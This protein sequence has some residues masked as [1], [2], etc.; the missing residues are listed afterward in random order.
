[1]SIIEIAI[2]AVI[3]AAVF[4]ALRRIVRMRRSG[5][6]CGCS[7]CCAACGGECGMTRGK[8]DGSKQAR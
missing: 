2:V 1:M 5:C 6:S 8:E 7:G 4:C 3:A